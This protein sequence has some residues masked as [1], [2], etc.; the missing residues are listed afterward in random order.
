MTSKTAKSEP[1]NKTAGNVIESIIG[2][3]IHVTG[4][5]MILHLQD[6]TVVPL[7]NAVVKG[8]KILNNYFLDLRGQSIPLESIASIELSAEANQWRS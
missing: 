7:K 3:Y 1:Q 4:I 5:N 8:D 6:N 2:K